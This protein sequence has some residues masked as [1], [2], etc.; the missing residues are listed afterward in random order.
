MR[1]PVKGVTA[2]ALEKKPIYYHFTNTERAMRV[3]KN[4]NNNI[5]CL[6]SKK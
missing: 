5:L 3:R 2:A 6:F 1:V 4:N